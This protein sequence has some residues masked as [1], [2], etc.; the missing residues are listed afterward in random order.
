MHL[1]LHQSK[2]ARYMTRSQSVEPQVQHDVENKLFYIDLG[3]SR[4]FITYEK[5]GHILQMT[6]TEVPKEYSGKG[7]GKLLAKVRCLAYGT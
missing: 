4:A 1:H 5:I 7:L 2:M 6:H 3:T